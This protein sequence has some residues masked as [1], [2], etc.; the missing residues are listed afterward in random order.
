MSITVELCGGLGNQ[1]FQVAT[2]LSLA[3]KTG[4]APY[5]PNVF[6]LPQAGNTDRRHTYYHV[7]KLPE[8][9]IEN[10]NVQDSIEISEKNGFKYQDISLEV[11]KNYIFRGYFQS[12]KYI[13]PSIELLKL[14]PTDRN[15]ISGILGNKTR[16]SIHV[17]HGDYLRLQHFHIVL[18]LD[19]YRKAWE[20]IQKPGEEYDVLIFSDDPEW[21]RENF[22]WIPLV[23][24]IS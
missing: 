8:N 24:S 23:G 18:P 19:Y 7:L 14:S 16:V 5:F 17:R 2:V 4:L 22:S 15:R 6:M 10:R 3:K 13:E 12:Y 9:S 20:L 21:C 1:L 11:G